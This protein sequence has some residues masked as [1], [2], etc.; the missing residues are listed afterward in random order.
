MTRNSNGQ[1]PPADGVPTNDERRMMTTSV[2]TVQ[3]PVGG[4]IAQEREG[5]TGEFPVV[6]NRP[7]PRDKDKD[8][9]K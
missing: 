6:A 8:K 7:P 5:F 9:D 2:P 4:S 3:V 1:H